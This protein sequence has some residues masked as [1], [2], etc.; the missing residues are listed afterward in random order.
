M[1]FCT[2]TDSCKE[3]PEIP[4][5]KHNG[6]AGQRLYPLGVQLVYECH[7]GYRVDGFYK[8][9]FLTDGKWMGPRMTC[10]RKCSAVQ[11]SLDCVIVVIVVILFLVAL[12]LDFGGFFID[13]FLK[14]IKVRYKRL[15]IKFL[16]LI[17]KSR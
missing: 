9:I 14:E 17:F 1:F 2:C 6:I 12:G 15:Q 5:A 16:N 3:A 11:C 13:I 10:E 8:A 7:P 4:N